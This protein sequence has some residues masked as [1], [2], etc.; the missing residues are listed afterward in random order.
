[1]ASKNATVTSVSQNQCPFGFSFCSTIANVTVG[2]WTNF[3]SDGSI[4]DAVRCPPNYCGCRNLPGYSQPICQL[5]PPFA[6]EFQPN[7]ALCDGNR[8]GVLCGGCR[9]NYTQSLNGFS[10]VRNE[11][12]LQ[13][14][15]WIWT[16]TVLGFIAFSIYIVVTSM[17]IDSGLIMCVMFYGQ[18][19]SFASVPPQ[20]DD[21]AQS[22]SWF[23]TVTQL[24]SIVS[25]YDDSCYGLNMGAYEAAAAQLCGPAIVVV[26]ALLL[27]AA[28]KWL[29]RRFTLFLQ[30]QKLCLGATLVNALLLL[31]SSVSSVV[32]QLITCQEVGPQNVVFID[33][34]Y[35]CV[36]S[37]LIAE[38]LIFS[39]S[40]SPI[41][42][43]RTH[44][45]GEY[46]YQIF[47]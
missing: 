2:F 9:L 20:F 1:V 37:S 11:I 5:F 7:D 6:V 43:P 38:W 36:Y 15:P 33:G 3:S 34:R 39:P 41:L 18:L 13:T 46:T 14:M 42:S 4:G 31:Y 45:C 22:S 29:Q 8:T 10:C 12:C 40:I 21:A 23:S 26:A 47:H 44:L 25:L 30:K 16:I 17:S 32:F 27:T 24:G 19:S 28:A 35:P